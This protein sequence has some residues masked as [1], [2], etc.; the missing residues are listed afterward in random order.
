MGKISIG[1]KSIIKSEKLIKNITLHYSIKDMEKHTAILI[2]IAGFRI[3]LINTLDEE[4]E[5]ENQKNLAYSAIN[6]IDYSVLLHKNILFQ[7]L[8]DVLPNNIIELIFVCSNN[9]N[10]IYIKDKGIEYNVEK[11]KTDSYIEQTNKNYE[12]KKKI[13]EIEHNMDFEQINENYDDKNIIEEIEH[14]I[15]VEQINIQTFH[16][17]NNKINET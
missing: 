11:I 4:I 5:K 9:F 10:Q 17:I 2:G 15:D 12:D 3:S 1:E 7:R 16:D 6:E 8:L 14:N 13:K